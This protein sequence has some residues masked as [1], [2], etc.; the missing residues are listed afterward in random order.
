MEDKKLTSP[1][2]TVKEINEKI[3]AG[4]AVVVTAEEFIGIADEDGIEKAAHSVDVVTTGT[5]GI[6]CSSGVMFNV[7]H[8]KPRMK[9]TKAWLNGV[10]AY[11]GL[12]AVD[13]FLGATELRE[14]DPANKIY[15]G[16]F[17]YGGGHVIEDLVAGRRIEFKAVGYGTDCYPAKEVHG[18]L[19]LED[20]NEALLLNPRNAYQNYNVAVNTSDR[21]IYTYLGMLLPKLGNANYCSAGQ[22]SPLLK[23]PYYKTVGIGSRC[24]LGGGEGY[25]IWHGTQHNPKVARNE[26]GIPLAGAGTLALLGDLKKMS[27]EFLRGASLTGYGTSLALGFGLPIPI[28]SA[29]IA[30]YAAVKDS[31]ISAPIVD[32]AHDYPN[33]VARNL[34]TVDYASLR[35]GSIKI[36]GKTVR[37]GSMSSYK[38]ARDVALTLK[39]WIAKGKFHLTEPV[40]KIPGP[41]DADAPVFH[42]L[43][44]K[45][46]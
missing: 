40:A 16:S 36:D 31:Q 19:K 3:A 44:L 34:G 21:I 10:L 5:F 35:S 18:Y 2:R 22:L 13:F 25:V 4:K 32:Y 24:F 46:Y 43:K 8:S 23:D 45:A 37:T 27:P 9:M 6:M 11:G 26:Y 12:A 42:G 1:I 15:P 38:K 29:E 30:K 39:D 7:G 28:L 33:G 41:D 17:K 14:D 20:L